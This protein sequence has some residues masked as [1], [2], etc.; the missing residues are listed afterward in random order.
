MNI[1]IPLN[2]RGERF[3]TPFPT[4]LCVL[5]TQRCKTPEPKPLIPIFEK[6][7]IEYVLDNLSVIKTDVIFIIYNKRLDPY[8][9]CKK[10]QQKYQNVKLIRL[11]EET[12]GAVETI[13]K[14]YTQIHHLLIHDKTIFIDGDTFYTT[15]IL[16]IF[17]NSNKNMIFYRKINGIENKYSFI[18]L[19]E[20]NGVLQIR[21]KEQISN[22]ANTGAYGFQNIN[23]FITF[24]KFILE[25]NIVFKNEPYISCAINEML[26]QNIHFVGQEISPNFIFSLGTPE[27][28]FHFIERTYGFLFDLDG[29]LVLTDEIYFN[30]WEQILEKYNLKL[31]TQLFKQFIQGQSDKNVCDILL[32]GIQV[33]VKDISVLKDTLFIENIHKIKIIPGIY[34]FL[35]EIKQNS[36]KISIVTNCNRKVAEAIIQ[37]INIEK[38]VDFL[39]S[40][41]DCQKGK[42]DK[43]PYLNAIQK[44]NIS[45]SKCIIFEDSK[46]GLLSGQTV[47]P[48]QL[49]GIETI[50]NETELKQYGVSGSFK[51]FTNVK[52]DDF[53][54]SSPNFG[55]KLKNI[56]TRH[57]ENQNV[58]INETKLK[59]GFICDVI[60]FIVENSK[61]KM[62]YILKYENTELN[63]LS[64]MA[65]QLELY[66][67]EYYFYK[68]IQPEINIHTAKYIKILKNEEY[69]NIGI[70]L[71]NLFKKN[72]KIN[73]NLNVENIDISLKIVNTMAKL[74]SHFWNH[75]L[76]KRFPQLKTSTSPCFYPFFQNYINEHIDT[77]IE[78]WSKILN[79]N[80]I[81]MFQHIASNFENIQLKMSQGHLTFIHGDIKSPN[82]FYDINNNINLI[83]WQ[84]C[85]IGKGTQDLIFFVIESFEIQNIKYIFP[86]FKNY[87]YKKLLE[88]GVKNYSYEEF[89]ID[90]KDAL[91]YIPFFTAVWFGTIPNDE[92][93][94]PCFPYFFISKLFY[95]MENININI[96]N[97]NP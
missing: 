90:L 73:L 11:E 40:N 44:F 59:G 85:A 80:Q 27:E 8:N 31:T 17:R 74:H 30:V 56:I 66:E 91:C 69:Q 49:I 87:Y 55:L 41:S 38:Y 45:N 54:N 68:E 60:D 88:Y 2:G 39:I 81:E 83:D 36:H 25:N 53:L 19:N 32:F 78:K 16:D 9:F 58:L 42:P 33:N 57:F 94:D 43:E 18:T 6:T 65:K 21:E 35:Q 86:L 92:L 82:I 84:H 71:E 77:F 3:L 15:D 13:V 63:Q 7:M 26:K 5:D 23:E 22:N 47:M 61:Q 64:I 34:D 51:D 20:N 24:G 46:S 89:E 28:V 62:F 12:K 48:Y 10:I 93:I 29:T 67:R 95:L 52:I 72:M 96:K 4:N 50:Y 97:L 75:K 1:I 14:A 76:E 79:P 70:V 37:Y